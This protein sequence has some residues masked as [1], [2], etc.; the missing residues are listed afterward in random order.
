[1]RHIDIANHETNQEEQTLLL[2]GSQYHLHQEKVD[3]DS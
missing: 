3:H 2:L 1:M